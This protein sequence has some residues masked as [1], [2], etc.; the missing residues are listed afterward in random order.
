MKSATDLGEKR[1]GEE[2]YCLKVLRVPLWSYSSFWAGVSE[3]N[4]HEIS[5]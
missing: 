1:E 3:T 4:V 5:L 2:R